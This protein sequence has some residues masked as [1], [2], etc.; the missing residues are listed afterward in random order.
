M[1]SKKTRLGGA[2]MAGLIA[3]TIVAAPAGARPQAAPGNSQ[4]PSAGATPKPTEADSRRYCVENRYTGS[5]L[6]RKTCKTRA[7]WIAQDGF[8]PLKPSRK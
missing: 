6:A 3:A 2:T 5:R 4:T 8:D 7:Q 1:T